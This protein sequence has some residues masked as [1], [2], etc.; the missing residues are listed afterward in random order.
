VVK[1]S[2]STEPSVWT[3]CSGSSR[4]QWNSRWCHSCVRAISN[5]L[6]AAGESANC[7]PPSGRNQHAI[8]DVEGGLARPRRGGYSGL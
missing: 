3:K 2:S 1:P 8:A 5:L 4:V 6:G 7:S